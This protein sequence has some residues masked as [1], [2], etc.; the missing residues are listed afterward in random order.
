[1]LEWKCPRCRGDGDI[2]HPTHGY[3]ICQPCY[4]QGY[5]LMMEQ[6]EPKHSFQVGDTVRVL[7][8]CDAGR[9][10]TVTLVAEPDGHDPDLVG[11]D[12]G[13]WISDLGYSYWDLEL[14]AKDES[15]HAG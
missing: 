10:G 9:I 11:V 5:V 2:T 15:K 8:G 6:L 7:T 12:L 13:V 4:R 1:M 3:R 14:V